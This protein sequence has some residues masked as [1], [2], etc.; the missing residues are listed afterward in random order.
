MIINNV[1][2]NAMMTILIL[3]LGYLILLIIKILEINIKEMIVKIAIWALT[4]KIPVNMNVE[5]SRPV[6][7]IGRPMKPLK[8]RWSAITLDRVNLKTPV[9]TI[10]KDI[11]AE[12]QINLGLS[13]LQIEYKIIPGATPK[14]TMSD[15]ASILFPK[16]YSSFRPIFL[17]TQPSAESQILA[18]IIDIAENLRYPSIDNRMDMNP[19]DKFNNVIKSGIDKKFFILVFLIFIN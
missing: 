10:N 6:A 8:S 11:M 9:I 15:K 14:D 1:S 2:I 7:V 13:I 3:N 17:A 18:K 12:M 4:W 5:I 19:N 16:P